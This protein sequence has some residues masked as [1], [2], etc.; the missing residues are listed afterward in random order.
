MLWKTKKSTAPVAKAKKGGKWCDV[1]AVVR[2]ALEMN[3]IGREGSNVT[4]QSESTVG[5]SE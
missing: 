3:V 4:E 2:Y 5:V 1:L